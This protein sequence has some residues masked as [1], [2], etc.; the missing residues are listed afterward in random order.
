MSTERDLGEFTVRATV[1]QEGMEVR[2]PIRLPEDVKRGD[3]LW[4]HISRAQLAS[5]VAAMLRGED[6]LP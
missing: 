6:R 4:V 3:I 2:L 5:L 1:G